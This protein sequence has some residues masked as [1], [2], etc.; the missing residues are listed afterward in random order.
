[1]KQT[2]KKIVKRWAPG[3]VPP[4]LA[5]R[6]RL[7]RTNSLLAWPASAVRTRL[8]R[9]RGL[10]AAQVARARPRLDVIKRK[11]EAAAGLAVTIG[12]TFRYWHALTAPRRAVAVSRQ[13]SARVVMLVVSDLRIDPR[14][15]RSATALAR[16][17]YRVTVLC[18]DLSSPPLREQPLDWGPGIEIRPLPWQAASYIMHFPWLFGDLMHEAAVAEKPFA[19][20]C[21]DLTTA[22][23]GLS[24][25]RQTGAR[26]I[27]DFHEWYSEN[28][29]WNVAGQCWEPHPRLKR[30]AYRLAER[31]ALERA[32]V[33]ITVCDSIA[34]ELSSELS[35]G[36][37]KVEVIRN[38]PSLVRNEA[39]HYPPLREALGIGRDQFLLLWQGGTGPSRMIEP[40]IEALKYAPAVT[41][42]IRGPSLDLFGAGYTTLAQQHGVESRLKLLPPVPSPDVVVAAE[43]AD[44]GVWTLPKLS[45]NFYYALPNKIFE[46]LASGLPILVANFPEAQRIVDR[47]EVG[48]SFDPYD[49]RSI[50]AQ[51]N[52]LAGEPGLAARMRANIP[53]ALLELDAHNEWN[54]LVAIYDRLSGRSAEALPPP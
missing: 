4:V 26:C 17:G 11:A 31:L 35:R 40:I 28:V 19:F 20:H 50:A 48:L 13:E 24:A 47:Y 3:L 38:I 21:H 44:A 49:P 32:D 37:R 8:A 29:S 46:Y 22:V 25:A 16:A 5:F 51:V 42:V 33:V 53:R 27:C 7:S 34:N 1:V 15:L 14:V 30:N 6:A 39:A 36:H 9:T 41:L 10:V 12:G 45:K 43:S 54:R 2:A 52:R 23:V 18:P